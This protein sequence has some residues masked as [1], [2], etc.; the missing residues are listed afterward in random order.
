MSSK[1]DINVLLEL[2]WNPLFDIER[3]KK[4][5]EAKK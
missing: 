5:F 1:A 3:N 2:G 4:I